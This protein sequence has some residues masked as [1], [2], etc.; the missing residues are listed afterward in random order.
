MGESLSEIIPK[1]LYKEVITNLKDRDYILADTRIASVSLYD[2]L[3]LTA[4]IAVATTGELLARRKTP[5]EICGKNISEKEL[6]SIIRIASLLHDWGKD[7]E[8]SG[9]APEKAYDKHTERSVEWAKQWL[10]KSN[11]EKQYVDLI[12]SAIERHHWDAKPKTLFEKIVCLADS[13]ASAGDRPEL[14]KATKHGEFERILESTFNLYNSVFSGEEGLVLILGDVDR[15][16]SYVYETSK[17]PE[18]RGGSEILNKLND[19]VLKEI[20]EES[21]SEECLIYYGGGS[22]LALAPKSIASEIMEKIEECYLSE[23]MFATITCVKSEPL[24]VYA[25]SRGLYPYVDED[26]KRLDGEGVG[27]WLLKSHFGEN[28]EEWPKVKGFGE[29]VS[30]LAAELKMKK[31]ER[32]CVPFFEALPIGMRCSSCGKRMVEKIEKIEDEENRLCNVCAKKRETSTEKKPRFRERFGKWLE[33]KKGLSIKD[34]YERFP[35]NLD[36]LAERYEDYMAFIYADGNDVGSL[37]FKA[38]SSAH[39]R[40]V[41]EALKIE[42]ENSLFEALYETI[43]EEKLRSLKIIPFEIIN[44]GGDDVSLILAAPYAFDFAEKFMENFEKKLEKWGITTSLGMVICKAKYPVYFAEKLAGSLLSDAKRKAKKSKTSE[45]KGESAFS[46]LYLTSQSGVE[47]YKEILD[48]YYRLESGRQ[49]YTLTMR[50]YTLRDLKK[51]LFYADKLEKEKL[52]TT[53]Q[54]NALAEALSKGMARS[55]NFLLYQIA[56]LGEEKG[57]KVMELLEDIDG[58]FNCENGW[59]LDKNEFVTPLL[60]LKE[61]FDIRRKKP[62]DET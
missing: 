36:E 27:E 1:N 49:R 10:E 29:V 44:I 13:L 2:H 28:K 3:R 19:E 22:F 61:I 51:L 6:I 33:E 53:S 48:S 24:Q 62:S 57:S 7:Y 4:G 9:L 55:I 40:H 16:K 17:L 30:L 18:I 52:F 59:R 23:T 11:I 50:P 56:R 54:L 46:F 5:E 31:M 25:F 21:L 14:A 39:Y 45:G 20:F 12:L 41:S 15:V 34:I 60:D 58:T 32:E 35:K 43:G 8:K 47:E 37:L 42:T 38:R 26:I